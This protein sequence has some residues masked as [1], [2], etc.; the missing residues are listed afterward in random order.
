MN[1]FR[2]ANRDL[3]PMLGVSIVFGAIGAAA[4]ISLATLSAPTFS[5]AALL[6]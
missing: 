2:T 5:L 1:V 3:M 4:I 6:P